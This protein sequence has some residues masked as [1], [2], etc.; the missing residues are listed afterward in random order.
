MILMM[1]HNQNKK[2]L[3]IKKNLSFF[4]KDFGATR[5]WIF[6]KKILVKIKK[7]F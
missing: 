4:K 5:A 1:H 3:K 6:L 7:Q 2:S